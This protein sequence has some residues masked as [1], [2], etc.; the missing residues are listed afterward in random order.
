[1]L[2]LHIE[3]THK[4]NNKHFVNKVINGPHVGAFLSGIINNNN[5]KEKN[6]LNQS[7]SV[8]YH[9]EKIETASFV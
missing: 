7:Q 3:N 6:K 1:M 5:E 2:I 9:H 8:F 4:I